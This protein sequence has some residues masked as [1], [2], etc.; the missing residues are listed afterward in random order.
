MKQ[1]AGSTLNI[2]GDNSEKRRFIEVT[3]DGTGSFGDE[4]EFEINIDGL[5]MLDPK[6]RVVD[7]DAMLDLLY[8]AIDDAV[9]ILGLDWDDVAVVLEMRRTE[10]E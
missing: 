8:S 3:V 2:S 5:G 6:V 9:N 10:M 7:N 1:K 4:A